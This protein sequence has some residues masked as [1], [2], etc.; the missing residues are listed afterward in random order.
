MV[1][2]TTR[3]KPAMIDV[4]NELG[5]SQNRL[6]EIG[7]GSHK[8]QRGRGGLQLPNEYYFPDSDLTVPM[9]KGEGVGEKVKQEKT[10]K[11][12]DT[13]PKWSDVV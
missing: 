12:K 7:P 11:T 9:K 5:F 6:P 2:E 13:T 1:K 8:P 10:D 3:P 4:S